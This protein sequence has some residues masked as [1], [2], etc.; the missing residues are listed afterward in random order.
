MPASSFDFS[1]LLTNTETPPIHSHNPSTSTLVSIHSD[2]NI[3]FHS[4]KSA[5]ISRQVIGYNDEIIDSIFLTPPPSPLSSSAA[6]SQRDTA[7]ALATNSSLIRVYSTTTQDAR[8][9]AGHTDMV[10][11]LDRSK[12]GEWLVSGSKDRT[13]RVWASVPVE[14]GDNVWRCIAICEG[15][16]ESIGAVAVSRKPLTDEGLLRSGIRSNFLFTAS[17]DRTIKM[18]DLTAIDLSSAEPSRLKSLLTQ[19]IHEKDINSLDVSPN[20]RLLATGSQDKT[21]KVFQVD[22]TPG[23]KGGRSAGAVSQLGTCKGH[24]RGVWSVKFSKTDKVLATGSGDKT[25]R[26]WS[27]DDFSCLK[28][29]RRSVCQTRFAG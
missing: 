23:R 28:V 27:L 1:R 22:F 8:L 13:A 19:K 12:D 20:D 21:V 29:R 7:I 18:W 14:G 25:V 15:H 6:S 16:A 10:L 26:V 24:K 5:T 4:L 11:C 9:L 3:L 17:Q 2:Q